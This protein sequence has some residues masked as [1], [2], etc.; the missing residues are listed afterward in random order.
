MGKLYKYMKHLLIIVIIAGLLWAGWIFFYQPY[1][2]QQDF[3]KQLI[4]QEIVAQTKVEQHKNNVNFE[5]KI[6]QYIPSGYY[7]LEN[8]AIYA[9][10]GN[11]NENYFTQTEGTFMMEYMNSNQA[12]FYIFQRPLKNNEDIAPTKETRKEWNAI[13]NVKLQNDNTA[14][15]AEKT[16]NDT[17]N[18]PNERPIDFSIDTSA[19]WF[20]VDNSFIRIQ[21][22]NTFA[23]GDAKIL[24]EKEFIKIANSF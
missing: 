10:F 19:L 6:S 22:T 18:I 21:A 3:K 12:H 1:K 5:V 9:G 14:Y 2:Q 13:K 20:V 4:E 16:E 23:A 8:S 11:K 24:S 15:F 17:L 7:L